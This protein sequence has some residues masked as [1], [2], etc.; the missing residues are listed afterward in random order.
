M[1]NTPIYLLSPKSENFDSAL[2]RENNRANKE[3]IELIINTIHKHTTYPT[4]GYGQYVD[5]DK[6]V[7][8]ITKEF[9]KERLDII[10]AH[11]IV[12]HP[13]AFTNDHYIDGR[14]SRKTTEWARAVYAKYSDSEKDIIIRQ[15][16]CLY[17]APHSHRTILESLIYKYI[18]Q[19]E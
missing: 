2:F 10:L 3:C 18:N 5:S 7:S 15:L 9:S 12:H 13:E 1:N 8:E 16:E 4:N 17:I 6:I 19:T 14:F 11:E